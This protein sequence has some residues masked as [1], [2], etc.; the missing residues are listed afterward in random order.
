PRGLDYWDRT[1]V[2][3]ILRNP[4]YKGLAAFGKK[5]SV[6]H[7]ALLRPRR[8]HPGPPR[9]AVSW[10]RVPLEECITIP[11]PAIVDAAVFDAVAEQLAEN[12]KRQRCS[13]GNA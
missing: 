9:R 8:A 6:P 5:R 4:C 10:Q 7:Q 12:K 3:T 1:T 11:V 2:C 13:C